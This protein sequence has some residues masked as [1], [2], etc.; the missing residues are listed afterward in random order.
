MTEQ[1]RIKMNEEFRKTLENVRFAGL[2]AGAKGIL[3]A[4]LEMCKS[5]KT[6]KDIEKFCETSLARAEFKGGDNNQRN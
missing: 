6:V 2:R 4:V 5:G 1:Q 3:G